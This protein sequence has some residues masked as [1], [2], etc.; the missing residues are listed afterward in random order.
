MKDTFQREPF[1]PCRSSSLFFLFQI[2]NDF[3]WFSSH[4]LIQINHAL[5]SFLNTELR[6]CKG[7]I[8]IWKRSFD[9]LQIFREFAHKFTNFII[10]DCQH[11]LIM[12]TLD[13]KKMLSVLLFC[14]QHH[15]PHIVTE[16]RYY[17]TISIWEI[18]KEVVLPNLKI[19]AERNFS[20]AKW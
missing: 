9:I 18:V 3:L 20:K 15:Q 17:V 8:N 13:D 12:E 16:L 19:R 11:S 4:T 2:Q 1:P 14:L 10:F 7:H 6:C 5:W